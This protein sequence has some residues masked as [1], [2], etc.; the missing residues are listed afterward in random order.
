[1]FKS[2]GV[3]TSSEAVLLK[4]SSKLFLDVFSDKINHGMISQNTI[5]K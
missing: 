3:V 4:I 2:G 1:M 5:L